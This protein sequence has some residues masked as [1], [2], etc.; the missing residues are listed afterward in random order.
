MQEIFKKHNN[1]QS[2]FRRIFLANMF[3]G[4]SVI[5]ILAVVFIPVMLSA[6]AQN[7]ER[8]EKILMMDAENAFNVVQQNVTDI[9][10]GIEGS[11]W[12]HNIFISHVLGKKSLF[13]GEKERIAKELSVMVGKHSLIKNISV[14]YY[15]EPDAIYSNNGVYTNL[16]FY[17]E[18]D[19][20]NVNFQFFHGADAEGFSTALVKGTEYLVYEKAITDVNGARAKGELNIVFRPGAVERLL[21]GGSGD[22]K[23]G[24]ELF[25]ENGEVVWRTGVDHN[26]GLYLIQSG[27]HE[28]GYRYGLCVPV[29]SHNSI[30]KR[31]VILAVIGL[32]ADLIVCFVF[33][34]YLSNQNYQPIGRLVSR[35]VGQNLNEENEIVSLE[36]SMNRLIEEK[37]LSE[38]ALGRLKPVAKYRILRRIL[39][40]SITKEEMDPEN[41]AFCDIT[42]TD[43]LFD[44]V[45]VKVENTEE[46][47][48][49]ITDAAMEMVTERWAVQYA[50]RAYLYSSDKNIYQLLLNHTCGFEMK[51]A[52]HELC[53]M[54]E[55]DVSIPVFGVGQTVNSVYEVFHAK[56]Q[57]VTAMNYAAVTDKKQQL[58]FYEEIEK[59]FSGYY[60]YPFTEEAMLSRAI[61]SGRAQ[62]AERILREIIAENRKR[63]AQMPQ[64]NLYLYS[65]L[66]STIKRSIQTLGISCAE[67]DGDV[68]EI[69]S[70][71]QIS[72]RISAMVESCCRQV[73]QMEELN[74]AADARKIIAYVDENITNPNLSLASIADV[75]GHSSSY[76]STVFKQFKEIGYSDYVN[77][78]RVRLA[79][80]LMCYQK[81]GIEEVAAAVGY[82]SVITFRRNFQKFMKR[83]PSE[84]T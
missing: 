17:Q 48:H 54:C 44:V 65:D 22:V 69:Y 62:D 73:K 76:V 25:N 10:E 6:A 47:N 75:F 74:D 51:A 24:F 28:N 81:M 21:L 63:N 19:P 8:Y 20:E 37:E 52:L 78:K 77:Q 31:T 26:D 56:D 35:Y 43:P 42:L 80:D 83:N 57:A 50:V 2:Y 36:Q 67:I 41:L 12:Y 68:S 4:I 33:A 32:I 53:L 39:N 38:L 27:I 61:I 55:S 1:R 3:L 71:G 40:G 82:V 49:E 58:I 14:I 16:P 60:Y 7:D 30:T 70:L 66:L 64:V 18:Q 13:A 79:A 84:Y 29:S 72:D 34:L 59:N 5:F 23:K 45:S 15:D 46:S 11:D 9:T